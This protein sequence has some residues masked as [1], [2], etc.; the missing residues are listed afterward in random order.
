MCQFF[1]GHVQPLDL[2]D[3]F[4]VLRQCHFGR[5]DLIRPAGGIIFWRDPVHL[6]RQF[7]S[8]DRPMA[9]VSSR[10]RRNDAKI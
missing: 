1:L 10:L 3:L 8:D 6:A 9:F 4:S 2:W 7:A 5:S